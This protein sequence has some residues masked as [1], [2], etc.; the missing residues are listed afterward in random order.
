[1]IL[2]D[3]TEIRY[4]SGNGRFTS[5]MAEYLDLR[6]DLPDGTTGDMASPWGH[7]ALIGRYHV[8]TDAQGFVSVE[9]YATRA[10]ANA[11]FDEIDSRYGV[12]LDT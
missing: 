9:R 5:G 12:W 10:E 1:M 2:T 4:S 7:V 6:C 3:G 8:I 11:I